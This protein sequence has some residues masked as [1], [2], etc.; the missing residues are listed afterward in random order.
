MAPKI[1]TSFMDGPIEKM[2]PSN[3]LLPTYHT[4]IGQTK[5][6]NF[7][8]LLKGLGSQKKVSHCTQNDLYPAAFSTFWLI[9]FFFFAL[10]VQV[11]TRTYSGLKYILQ[12][13]TIF[14]APL[15][16]NYQIFRIKIKHS[17]CHIST[18]KLICNSQCKILLTHYGTDKANPQTG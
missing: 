6:F 7:C 9:S 11:Q 16:L 17:Y 4:C 3:V 12:E 2:H 13:I 8:K 5:L 15:C 18:L 14:S 1:P 10:L